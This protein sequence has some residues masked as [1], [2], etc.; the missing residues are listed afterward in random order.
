MAETG[1]LILVVGASGAGKD[2]L[3]D[4]A[5]QALRNDAS[6]V[7]AQREI[8][9][10]A[11]AGGEAHIAV[12]WE[13]FGARRASAGYALAWEAHG[14]GY[15]VPAAIAADLAAGRTVVVNASRSVLDEVRRKFSRVRIV[16]VIAPSDVLAARLSARGRES[17]GDLGARLARAGD[18]AVVGDD[19]VT[20][21]NDGTIVEGAARFLAALQA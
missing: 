19:V 8:T 11:E 13:T 1:Q 15:G 4:A 14:L 2:T 10:P 3:I 16:N 18:Q 5:R 7:F 9:R 21:L 6:V 12:D 17:D 20:V